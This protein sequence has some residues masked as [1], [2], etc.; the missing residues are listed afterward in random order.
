VHEEG[1]EVQRRLIRP[2]KILEDEH[3]R[4]LLAEPPEQRER[5]LEEPQPRAGAIFAGL[6]GGV[7]TREARDQA[8]KL[9]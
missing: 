3:E 7:L 6:L 4:L 5:L 9:A 8:G 2:M 1:D